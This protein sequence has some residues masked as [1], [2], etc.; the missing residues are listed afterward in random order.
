MGN[1]DNDNSSFLNTIA[2]FSENPYFIYTYKYVL[3]VCKTFKCKFYILVREPG[4]QCQG[5][6]QQKNV[7]NVR[8]SNIYCESIINQ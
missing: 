4:D 5:R 3:I 8:F 1:D 2:T 7:Y 6:A